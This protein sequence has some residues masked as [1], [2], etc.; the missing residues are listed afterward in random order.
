MGFQVGFSGSTFSFFGNRRLRTK[1]QCL[2]ESFPI[3]YDYLPNDVICNIAIFSGDSTLHSEAV[4]RRCSV[5]KVFLKNFPIFTGKHL[6]CSLFLIKM[7][8]WRPA[9]LIKSDSSTGFLSVNIGKVL[10]TTILKKICEW[11]LLSAL[12]LS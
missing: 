2:R 1:I 3:T 6:C 5:K 4:A 7:Q 9:F 8:V 10:R 11:L 12:T